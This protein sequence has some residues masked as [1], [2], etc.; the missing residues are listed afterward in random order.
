MTR[1]YFASIGGAYL[2]SA[3]DQYPDHPLRAVL[4]TVLG[5]GFTLG[6]ILWKDSSPK[7]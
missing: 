2:Q 3:F 7:V 1:L 5:V 6:A 4:F